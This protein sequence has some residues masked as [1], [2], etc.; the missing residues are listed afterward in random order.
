MLK[1]GIQNNRESNIGDA[2]VHLNE[3]HNTVFI[4]FMQKGKLVRYSI[5][6]HN[7]NRKRFYLDEF[8]AFISKHIA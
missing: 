7:R 8:L 5:S 3:K 2:G 6:T 1:A 4:I